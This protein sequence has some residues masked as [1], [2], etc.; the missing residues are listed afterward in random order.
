M[1]C[2]QLLEA[3]YR[4][5]LFLCSY[6]YLICEWTKP[7]ILLCANGVILLLFPLM[8]TKEMLYNFV[9]P[10]VFLHFFLC[11]VAPIL[12]T[13]TQAISSDTLWAM[14]VSIDCITVKVKAVIKHGAGGHAILSP[15][16]L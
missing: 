11:G 10:S 12:C 16:F 2:I 3:F 13:L 7:H 6:F 15:D 14:T 8:C 9:F 1:L 4:V 5:C